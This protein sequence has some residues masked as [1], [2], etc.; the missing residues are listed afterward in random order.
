MEQ[1]ALMRE[2]V[3]RPNLVSDW[4]AAPHYRRTVHD[5]VRMRCCA[6][7]A[8]GKPRGDWHVS[9]YAVLCGEALRYMLG[10]RRLGRPR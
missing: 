2:E 5:A 7:S 6:I 10:A 8:R 9:N 4:P 3:E 1:L